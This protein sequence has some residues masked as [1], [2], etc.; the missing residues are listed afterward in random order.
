MKISFIDL[1]VVKLS[2]DTKIHRGTMN[3]ITV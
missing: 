2:I 3:E 1:L